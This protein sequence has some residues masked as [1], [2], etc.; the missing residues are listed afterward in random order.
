MGIYVFE[1]SNIWNY[2]EDRLDYEDNKVRTRTPKENKLNI[3]S[4]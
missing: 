3:I 4:P 2:R 1:V